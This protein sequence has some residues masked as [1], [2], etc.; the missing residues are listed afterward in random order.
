MN[1]LE[2]AI[3]YEIGLSSIYKYNGFFRRVST[4][5][6]DLDLN[7]SKQIDDVLGL[8]REFHNLLQRNEDGVTN[9]YT[10]DFGLLS[11]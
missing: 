8:T 3:N 4:Q 7:P 2:K 5:K 10:Y 1:R 9:S 6:G 11:V